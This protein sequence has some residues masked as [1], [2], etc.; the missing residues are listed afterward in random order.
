MKS[1]LP[2]N[3][4]THI[5]S[6][7]NSSVIGR[8]PNRSANRSANRDKSSPV[9]PVIHGRCRRRRWLDKDVGS[10]SAGAV[11]HGIPVKGRKNHIRVDVPDGAAGGRRLVSSMI[12]QRGGRNTEFICLL[13]NTCRG[14]SGENIVVL[15]FFT[16]VTN[17]TGKLQCFTR[18]FLSQS[19]QI[20]TLIIV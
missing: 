15:S 6:H 8:Q 17:F 16:N 9:A 4:H 20:V 2:S 13:T 14:R 12:R 10:S 18:V 5:L 1:Q 19:S 11:I 3:T 7:H